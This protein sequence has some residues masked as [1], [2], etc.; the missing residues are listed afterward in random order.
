VRFLVDENLSPRVAVL[1][2]QAGH[3]AVH[4]RDV[5]A[6][7]TPDADV[8]VMAQS[9]ERIIVSADT[10]F[11][12][13]IAQAKAVT[14]SV[15]LV[16][17]FV[18]LRPPELAS[19]LLEHL[20]LIKKDLEAGVDALDPSVCR[21]QNPVTIA[22]LVQRLSTRRGPELVVARAPARHVSASTR[23]WRWQ[24]IISV[25]G[26]PWLLPARANCIGGSRKRNVT[27]ALLCAQGARQG[28]EP[29]S[30]QT[31]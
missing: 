28:Y 3:D 8:M 1:L 27:C 17:E 14:P 4:V 7:R 11:G 12:A 9:Q 20:D 6:A 26:E 24:A 25:T 29:C 5:L 10:D 31:S 21:A 2:S 19:L 15:L 18:E 22:E 23:S 13:L 30:P 16:R